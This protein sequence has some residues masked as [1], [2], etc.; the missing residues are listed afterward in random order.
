MPYPKHEKALARAN[1]D[2]KAGVREVPLGS[3]TGPR[4]REMQGH[5]WLGGTRWPWCVA[6][7][8]TWAEEAGFVL[9]YQGAGAYAFLDWARRNGWSKPLSRAIPGDFVVF[10]IGAGHMAMLVEYDARAGTVET[11]DGNSSDRVRRVLRSASLVRG[12]VTLP[13]K[14]HKIPAAKPPLFEVVTSESGHKVITVST[15]SGLAKK[16]EKLLKK[17]PT[18]TIRRRKRKK[19]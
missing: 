4:V 3:N 18:L 14:P 12:A 19:P 5:T 8:V 15:A 1:A 7:C 10:N 9:P 16:L 2:L 11:I 17:H 13:E 6:A